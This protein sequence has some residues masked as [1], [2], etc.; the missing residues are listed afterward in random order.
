ME[1]PELYSLSTKP[2]IH[3]LETPPE[4]KIIDAEVLI[5][6]TFELDEKA[7]MELLFRRY[8]SVLCSHAIRYV[9]S[10][11]VAED[12]VSDIF[13]EFQSKGLYRVVSTSYRAYLFTSV[14]NR[15]YDLVR[16]GTHQ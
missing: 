14:R 10:R 13:F 1:H 15:A 12:I 2:K 7:G 3:A 6:K 9:S 8:Y 4:A 16:K 5:Q 11:A